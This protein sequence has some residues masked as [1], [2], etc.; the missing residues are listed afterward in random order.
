[1]FGDAE[2]LKLFGGE[3]CLAFTD[4]TEWR[5]TDNEEEYL[6]SYARLV[7]WGRNK[8]VLTIEQMEH[9]LR[10]AERHPEEAKAALEDAI[11]LRE[12]IYRIFSA[13]AN[14]QSP[15]PTDLATFN[16]ALSEALVWL[17]VVPTGTGFSWDWADTDSRLDWLLWP[18][19]RSA[20]E[21]LSSQRLDR[22]KQCA[23][24]CTWLFLDTS[25][26]RSRRWCTMRVCGNRAKA[27][28]FYRRRQ[29]RSEDRRRDQHAIDG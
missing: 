27:R 28:R 15:E 16:S 21:L 20:A 23:G 10:K 1:M 9:L 18:V 17:R 3:L 14:G 24:G 5:G 7:A 19:V 22:V 25:R 26:N 13:I 11:D 2:Q 6:T 12:A 8:G 4:T 29:K